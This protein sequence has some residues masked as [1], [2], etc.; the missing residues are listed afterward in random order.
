MMRLKNLGMVPVGLEDITTIMNYPAGTSLAENE[1]EL[2][3]SSFKN[4]VWAKI[5]DGS[6]RDNGEIS[7][8]Q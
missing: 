3:K 8:M 7:E 5:D 1:Y 2:A 6:G 4:N